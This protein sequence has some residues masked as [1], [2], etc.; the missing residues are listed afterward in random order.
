[1]V[2]LA[3][4]SRIRNKA[5]TRQNKQCAICKK[6]KRLL[7][8]LVFFTHRNKSHWSAKRKL[9][10]IDWNDY[11]WVCRDCAEKVS[12]VWKVSKDTIKILEEQVIKG[13]SVYGWN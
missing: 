13:Q 8:S 7:E 1:M 2:Y 4:N 6:I 3:F 11:R 10:I 12:T 5:R 9:W